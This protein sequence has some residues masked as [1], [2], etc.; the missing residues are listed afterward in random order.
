[1][2]YP[3]PDYFLALRF[4]ERLAAGD[5][6]PDLDPVLL[7]HALLTQLNILLGQN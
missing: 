6:P 1:M 5:I 4:L 7:E 3:P 2:S